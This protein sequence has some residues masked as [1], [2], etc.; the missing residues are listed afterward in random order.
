MEQQQAFSPGLL[1]SVAPENFSELHLA[2]E[3]GHDEFD[4]EEYEAQRAGDSL[5]Q[6]ALSFLKIT[7]VK[8]GLSRP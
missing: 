5:T 4:W 1:Y 7:A 3:A 8:W 6:I 2:G